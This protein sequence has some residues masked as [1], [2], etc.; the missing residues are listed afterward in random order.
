[1]SVCNVDVRKRWVVI[2]D[3]WIHKIIWFVYADTTINDTSTTGS[4]HSTTTESLTTESLTTT[5][6]LT[7][8]TSTTRNHI[9]MEQTTIGNGGSMFLQEQ[10]SNFNYS[11]VI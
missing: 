1:M 3:F 2:K 6:L 7:T 9:Y 5:E 4:L 11:D 8:T 10:F